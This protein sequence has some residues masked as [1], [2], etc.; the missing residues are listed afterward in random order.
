MGSPIVWVRSRSVFQPPVVVVADRVEADP[1]V[2]ARSRWDWH[3]RRTARPPSRRG[4]AAGRRSRRWPPR[5]SRGGGGRAACR[6]VRPAARRPRSG[7]GRPSRP[8][9]VHLPE[10]QPALRDDPPGGRRRVLRRRHA[11][12]GE[13]SANQ[14]AHRSASSPVASRSRPGTGVA[15]TSRSSRNSRCRTATAARPPVRAAYA[16]AKSATSAAGPAAPGRRGPATAAATA[17][18]A[19]GAPGG[20]GETSRPRGGVRSATPATAPSASRSQPSHS[21]PRS[22]VPS[23]RLSSTVACTVLRTG[24]RSSQGR[25]RRPY[26]ARSVSTTHSTPPASLGA[27]PDFAR[28]GSHGLEVSGEVRHRAC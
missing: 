17:A 16:V 2:D 23:S 18:S 11:G 24:S 27:P 22:A 12:L 15:G 19:T 25:T 3:G 1:P 20:S 6:P 8:P 4:P 28:L 26:A 5:R 9:A 13:K 10:Q 14:A 7:C 21:P